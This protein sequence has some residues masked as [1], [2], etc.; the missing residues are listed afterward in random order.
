M[1]TQPP[2][3]TIDEHVSIRNKKKKRRRQQPRM[4]KTF[5]FILSTH[6]IG[7]YTKR[8][9]I[10]TESSHRFASNCRQ[11]CVYYLNCSWIKTR[12]I[13]LD[14]IIRADVLFN[15]NQR[16]PQLGKYSTFGLESQLI[17]NKVISWN[18]NGTI[19]KKNNIQRGNR[20]IPNFIQS[21]SKAL[22]FGRF[23]CTL[24]QRL[25]NSF[26]R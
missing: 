15:G 17:L 21:A 3:S 6:N 16:R 8:S 26:K 23:V 9:S 2:E 24:P 11:C 14:R 18:G 4:E 7:R 19:Y 25:V 1:C 12:T 10:M 5:S 22:M 13:P 20:P